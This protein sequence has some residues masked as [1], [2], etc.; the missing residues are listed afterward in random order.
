M[1]KIEQLTP[2]D[3]TDVLN[4]LKRDIEISF[5]CVQIGIVQDFNSADQTASVQIALKKIVGESAD[6]TRTYEERPILLK[7]PVVILYGGNSYMSFPITA[8]DNCLVVFNDREIDNWWSKGGV[9]N[10]TTKRAHDIADAMAIVGLRSL[11]NSITNYLTNGIRIQRN[12][13][14]KIELTDALIESFATLFKHNGDAEITGNTL[15]NGNLTILGTTFGSGGSWVIDADIDQASGREI[16]AGN[17]ANGTFDTVT[18]VDGIVV[19]GS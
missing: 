5:N 14:T 9:Q 6:G 18:V 4:E 2:P 13:G 12:S 8:G 11:Q 10:T 1:T 19:S 16:H 15:I 7:V 3:L 17:G